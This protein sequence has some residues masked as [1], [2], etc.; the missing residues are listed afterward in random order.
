MTD[1]YLSEFPHSPYTPS[2]RQSETPLNPLVDSS[3]SQED[4][5]LAF[6]YPRDMEF[7]QETLYKRN[8][9]SVSDIVCNSSNPDLS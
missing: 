4:L 2:A 8:L 5:D 9:K 1:P 6:L 7:R 3:N